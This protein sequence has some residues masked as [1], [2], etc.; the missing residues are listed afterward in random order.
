MNFEEVLHYDPFSGVFYWLKKERSVKKFLQIT[1]IKGKSKY[2][3]V[4]VN[5]KTYA[6]HRLA[7]RLYYGSWPKGQIDHIDGDTGNNRID[8]LRDVSKN[9]NMQNLKKHRK[10]KLFGAHLLRREGCM[11]RWQCSI[12][13]EG[14][15]VYLGCYYTAEEANQR[16]VAYAKEHGL[17]LLGG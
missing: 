2:A 3:K 8:N 14:N 7:W 5:G 15:S 13:H 10:G 6:A 16:A 11:D 1:G 17:P 12:N 4:Q 9:E